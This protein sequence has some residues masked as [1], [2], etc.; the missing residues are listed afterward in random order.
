MK[1]TKTLLAVAA[2]LML[3]QVNEAFAN[4]PAK[5]SDTCY[6]YSGRIDYSDP[7]N[8]VLHY[9]DCTIT[10]KFSGTSVKGIFSD[11]SGYESY[12]NRIAFFIDDQPYFIDTLAKGGKNQI[13]EIASGLTDGIHTLT[14]VKL[15]ASGSGFGGLTFSGLILDEGDTLIKPEKKSRL[16][17]EIYGDSVTEGTSAGCPDGTNDC[18]DHNVLLSYG[19]L[20]ANKLDV[21]YFNLG[22]GGLAVLNNTGWYNSG[23]TGLETTYNKVEPLGSQVWDFSK[24]TPDVVVFAL[25]VN[26]QSKNGFAN[27]PYW[28]SKYKSI[29]KSVYAQYKGSPNLF[30][31]VAPF[32]TTVAYQYVGELA[33]ELKAEGLPVYFY[34]CPFTVAGHPNRVESARMADSLYL[35][36]TK[37][38]IFTHK[39][40]DVTKPGSVGS[41]EVAQKQS[42]LVTIKWGKA[43]DDRAIYHYNIY[44]NNKTYTSDS[45]YIT[46]TGLN[47]STEYDIE[48][49]AVDYGLNISEKKLASFKTAEFDTKDGIRI[50][51]APSDITID[52]LANENAWKCAENYNVANLIKGEEASASLTGKFKALWTEKGLYIFT[53][54][55]DTIVV[56]K[57][58]LKSYHTTFYI[59]AAN[60]KS[61]RLDANDFIIYFTHNS[62]AIMD[63][64]N[65][66]SLV[67]VSF[68]EANTSAGYNLECYIP[69]AVIGITPSK[70]QAFGFDLEI[71]G[72]NNSR[73]WWNTTE[74][75]LS[76]PSTY[77][78]AVLDTTVGTPTAVNIAKRNSELK[79]YPNPGTGIFNLSLSSQSIDID[80]LIVYNNLGQTVASFAKNELSVSGNVVTVNL[81]GLKSG[82]YIVK[83]VSKSKQETAQLTIMR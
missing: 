44:C 28:K 9:S 80:R 69:W 57:P 48:I 19:H 67:G 59:D 31:T 68:K 70:F 39:S 41:I 49:E 15:S 81:S 42:T 27:V 23:A 32:G 64:N 35:Y 60:N 17:M 71:K 13:I 47:P 52:G 5:P 12:G 77:A 7:D 16:K 50:K 8:P 22:I 24:F 56:S 54:M 82:S 33:A 76:N 40:A 78:I 21:D 72:K 1:T 34:I 38:D 4:N 6:V 3:L 65:S 2:C 61:S 51:K 58:T 11:G 63:Q 14:I 66:A 18:G 83:V 10:T 46:I 53:Q 36:M 25:G 30:F 45:A 55:F 62:T 43:S 37:N 75:S 26:D 79:I 29:V 73:A 74:S 20:L